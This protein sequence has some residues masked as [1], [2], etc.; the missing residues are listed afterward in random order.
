MG[1]EGFGKLSG[2]AKTCG[3]GNFIQGKGGGQ[4]KFTGFLQAIIAQINLRGKAGFLLEKTEKI[5]SVD[6]GLPGNGTD[7]QGIGIILVKI[8]KRC[9]QVFTAEGGGGQG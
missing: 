5:G 8:M 1:F 2:A 6:T 4:K 3:G 9:F 7:F